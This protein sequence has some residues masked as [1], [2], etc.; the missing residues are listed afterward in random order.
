M[1][2]AILFATLIV[3]AV[4]LPAFFM[5]GEAGAF[6]PAIATAYLLAIVAS[7]GG[8]PHG[9]ARPRHDAAGRRRRE[10]GASLRWPAG[11]VGGT[12]GIAPGSCRSQ[13]PPSPS[14][15]VLA[16]R[17]PRGVAVPRPFDAPGPEGAGRGGPARRRSPARRLGGWTR[18]RRRPSRSCAP[19]R[20]STTW[21]PTSV[22]PCSRTR[23]STS[24]PRRSGS[25]STSRPTT[26]KRSASIETAAGDLPGRVERRTDLLRAADHRRPRARATTRSSCADL[27]PGPADPRD[28]GGG[29][30]CGDRRH[31]RSRGPAGPAAGRGA[32]DR[33]GAGHR[34]CGA[35]TASPRATCGVL[36]RPCCRASSSATCS[37]S[38]RCSTWRCGERRRSVQ[39]ETDVENL[40][41]RHARGRVSC[42]LG[43]VADVRV[44][45]NPAVIRHESVESYVDV[46]GQRLRTSRRRR[47]G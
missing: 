44:V 41:D 20:A 46:G 16:A 21:A 25:A 26:A 2:S 7:H 35:S 37:R 33:G 8:R 30:A 42:A 39:S 38:R 45:P 14:F 6:L 34:P 28:Q 19:C 36:P 12:T 18:S 13:V 1:R 17:R 24:T 3:A 22:A 5:E 27:R 47:R 23:S 32:H 31:R 43:E 4:L 10:S 29:G 15:G 40:V 9:H 11:C